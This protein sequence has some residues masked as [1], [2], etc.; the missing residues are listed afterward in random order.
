MRFAF[1]LIRLD[2]LLAFQRKGPVQTVSNLQS[3]LR[4]IYGVALTQNSIDSN[5]QV[6]Y[7]LTQ[8]KKI[9]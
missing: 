1:L 5:S 9:I 2:I 7:A 6:N 8:R 3:Q 4:N